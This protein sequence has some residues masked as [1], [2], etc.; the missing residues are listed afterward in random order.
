MNIRVFRFFRTLHAWGGVTLALLMLVISLTGTLIIWKRDYVWLTV[1]EA[2]QAFTPDA[3][4][5]ARLA[6][7]AEARFADTQ[8]LQ[9]DFATEDF[10]LTK[11]TLDNSRYAYLDPAG[12]VAA[13]WTGNGRIEE[14]LYDLHHRLLLENLGLTVVGF[15]SMAM[16]ILLIAGLVS[17]WPMRRGFGEGWI[18]RSAAPR[19]LRSAHR[20]IGVVVA[21]PFLMSLVTGVMLVYPD[22]STKLL[23][24]PFRAEDYSLDFDQHVD[25]ISGGE[26][27]QWLPALQRSLAVFP[28]STVRSAQVPGIGSSYR[29]MGLQQPG[30]LN[31]PGH[32]QGLC[33]RRLG[34]HG[35][36]H[37]LAGPACVGAPLQCR[38]S[39]AHRAFRQ[40]ALQDSADAGGS[41]GGSAQHAGAG[42]FREERMMIIKGGCACG[43]VRFES[44]AA[45]LVTRVCWCRVCQYLGA[46]SGTVN[47]MFATETFSSQGPTSSHRFVADSGNVIHRDFC[48]KCGT[49]LFS[50]AEVRPHLIGV[51]V[52]ALDDPEQVRPEMTIWASQA[53]S[54]ACIASDIPRMDGQAPPPKT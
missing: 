36:S 1:P 31:P 49:S 53:P 37:R 29:V 23:L 51:R 20:N 50:R 7:A 34:L 21:L 25:K 54:W 3:A 30:E 8:I 14:W 18:P 38:L 41:A 24:E 32:E 39:A 43:A 22:E 16:V 47:T 2:R 35:H 19:H 33:R 40:P 48:G 44:S 11:V 12:N 4:S 13:Q 46:G 42:Q 45:P 9:I 5:L 15:G 52:G 10:A 27:G 26:S 28:G 6:E 17:Y